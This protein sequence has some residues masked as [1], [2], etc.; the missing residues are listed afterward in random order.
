M[1][2]TPSKKRR[3]GPLGQSILPLQ[4]TERSTVVLKEEDEDKWKDK[5]LWLIQLPA[6]VNS[7]LLMY[8]VTVISDYIICTKLRL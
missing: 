1:T 8:A 5:E 4:D 7:L 2:Q 3:K 6:N